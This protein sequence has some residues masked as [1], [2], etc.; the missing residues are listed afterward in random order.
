MNYKMKLIMKIQWVQM[1]NN[2]FDTQVGNVT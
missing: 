1:P 2:A